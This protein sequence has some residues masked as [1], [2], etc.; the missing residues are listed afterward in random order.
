MYKINNNGGLP[1]FI[2][3][4]HEKMN[5]IAVMFVVFW[6]L[7]FYNAW[8]HL[9]HIHKEFFEY[10]IAKN[11]KDVDIIAKL[12]CK[13]CRKYTARIQADPHLKGVAKLEMNIFVYGTEFITKHTISDLHS[14]GRQ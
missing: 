7:F 1:G 10:D 5:I 2:Y 8:Q 3:M 12:W 11:H 9:G 13:S 4:C 14:M 6:G